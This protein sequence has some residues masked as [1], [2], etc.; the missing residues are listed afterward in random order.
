M[1][2]SWLVL[3]LALG[4]CALTPYQKV[5]AALV[6]SGVPEP[7]A[8][9][10]ADRMTKKLSVNQLLELRYLS[11]A[12]ND[13]GHFSAGEFVHRLREIDDPEVVLVTSKAALR[14]SVTA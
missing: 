11:H 3:L 12:K 7:V 2:K 10:M 8:G 9:C 6:E 13:E 5:R 14:C 1:R 4:G